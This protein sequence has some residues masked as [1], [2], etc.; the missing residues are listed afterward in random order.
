MIGP[1]V[2]VGGRDGPHPPLGLGGESGSLI[3]GGGCY[4]NL[5]S[6]FVDGLCGGS[7]DLTLFL[8][9]FLNLC[10]LLALLRWSTDL[11][12]ED[13]V[14]NL[15]LSQRGHVDTGGDGDSH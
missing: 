13:D 9:L 12:T 4:D 6:M 14:S 7:C 8:C 1:E 3:V 11:H 15:R 2:K 5:V 10:N